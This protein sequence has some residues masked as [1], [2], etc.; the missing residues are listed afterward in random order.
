[1]EHNR[2]KHGMMNKMVI[3]LFFFSFSVMKREETAMFGTHVVV[4]DI[5]IC[6]AREILFHKHA[7]IYIQKKVQTLQEM[8]QKKN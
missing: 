6:S 1:M 5:S 8:K 4:V 3:L 7:Y 2:K